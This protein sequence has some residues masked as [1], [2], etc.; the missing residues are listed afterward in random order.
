MNVLGL[1]FRG[2]CRAAVETPVAGHC[3]FIVTVNADFIVRAREG[4]ERL[5]RI[6]DTHYSTFDGFWPWLIARLRHPGEPCDKISGSDLIYRYA[7]QCHVAGR[8]LLILGG[9][10]G[11]A[12]EAARRL[13]ER[14]GGNGAHSW[15]PPFE[16]YPM[17]QGYID[18]LRDR[19]KALQP[20]AVAVCL[21]SPKQEFLIEDQLEFFS[22]NGVSFACGAGG[23]VD[24]MAGR[25]KRA[26]LFVQNIGL[27]GVWR[28]LAQPSMFRLKRLLLSFRLFRYYF[29]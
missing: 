29:D 19:V 11:V 24:F 3:K 9:G 1:T 13:N 5:R 28:L 14:F 25:I 7:E 2:A 21:G 18:A 6:I 15:E 22:A 27:E 8:T 23:T 12:P 4:D 26:P 16:P 17:S 20:M 10:P